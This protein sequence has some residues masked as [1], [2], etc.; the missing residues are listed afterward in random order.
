MRRPRFSAPSALAAAAALVGLVG[1]VSALTPE[2]A[3]RSDFVRGVLPPGVPATARVLTFALGVGLVWLSRALARRKRRAW[4]L[5]VALVAVSAIA[6]LAKGLDFEEAFFS[7][8][9]LAALWRYRDR[10][11]APGDAEATRRLLEAVVALAGVALL[12][13]LRVWNR[14][15][16]VADLSEDSL[17][18]VAGALGARAFYLWLRPASHRVEQTA[19]ERRQAARLVTEWGRDSLCY[20][21]LRRD[22]SYFFSPSGGSFL[23]YRVVNGTALVSGD[24]IGDE[25]ELGELLAE[26]RR[27]AQSRGWRFAVVGASEE[28]LPLYRSVGLRAVYLGDEAVVDPAVFSLEGR[29]IRKV[30]QSVA[31]LE[32]AGFRVRVLPGRGAD[33]RLRAE[34]AK[35]SSAWRGRWP[36][37]GFGMAMDALFEHDDSL[38]AVAD[39]LDGRVGGFVQLVPSP[40]SGGWSVATM[41]RRSDT[42]NGLMEFLLVRVV[43]W[44][45]A[46][47]VTELSLNFAV[48]GEILRGRGSGSL[49]R[50][51]VRVVL[52]PLDRVFQLDR[53]LSFSAKFAPSWRARYICIERLADF[54][55]VGL[56][57][58]HAESLLTP[59]GPWVRT[60]DLANH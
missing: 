25:G 22:K 23:A 31:R 34:L 33:A 41:R 21:A 46:N 39:G 6:H 35:V 42:P 3:S 7:L 9:V 58:L 13:A 38:L 57:Y 17:A 36:E 4:Q 55:L 19:A 59:P 50:R 5:A 27:L 10:F 56:A 26:F 43:D 37:R 29:R 15:G 1:V 53:L 48:F 18:L 44:A 14:A 8:L 40:A 32:R 60:S 45:Q 51:A 16:D 24:P 54:P 20:F 47:A 28:R 11:T 30:R 49:W 12:L 2:L 52:V